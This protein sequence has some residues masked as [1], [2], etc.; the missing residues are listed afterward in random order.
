M[1]FFFSEFR[2]RRICLHSLNFSFFFLK[3]EIAI[4]LVGCFEE[5]AERRE[6][7]WTCDYFSWVWI[8]ID[9]RAHQDFSLWLFFFF[10][11]NISK[12][13]VSDFQMELQLLDRFHEKL[14]GL[15]HSSSIV[16]FSCTSFTEVN[17][18]GIDER[19]AVQGVCVCVCVC[20][21]CNKKCFSWINIC[22][23]LKKEANKMILKW[24]MLHYLKL[25]KWSLINC[26]FILLSTRL[27]CVDLLSF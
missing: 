6:L 11:L 14:C 3:K 21:M 8:S 17:W 1:R 12:G 7:D 15:S 13:F 20:V 26:I 16:Y 9:F 19:L 24:L 5:N 23:L 2:L 25:L 27:H 22:L 4:L 10:F 18:A